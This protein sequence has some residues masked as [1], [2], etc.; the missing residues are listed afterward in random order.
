MDGHTS[1]WI[2]YVPNEHS[3]LTTHACT[4][5]HTQSHLLHGFHFYS[6]INDLLHFE[7]EPAVNSCQVVQLIDAVLALFQR[8]S[9]KPDAFVC[10][11]T[12]VL[13]E[14]TELSRVIQSYAELYRVMQ[15]YTEL[16]RVMLG[17]TDEMYKASYSLNRCTYVSGLLH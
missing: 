1:Y 6:P 2:E 7:E 10:W 15:S 14:Y 4:H 16:C 11:L 9:N 8:S 3:K 17:Y 12:Q 13:Q 5:K